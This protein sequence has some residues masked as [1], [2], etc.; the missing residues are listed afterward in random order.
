MAYITKSLCMNIDEVSVI[1]DQMDD[2]N[3]ITVDILLM[4]HYAYHHNDTDFDGGLKLIDK[5]YHKLGLYY[6]I[7]WD[8]ES[9]KSII[10]TSPNPEVDYHIILNQLLTP[11]MIACFGV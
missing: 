1:L 2:I 9:I 4:I 5:L 7:S 11:G 8:V 10:R 3:E 6:D